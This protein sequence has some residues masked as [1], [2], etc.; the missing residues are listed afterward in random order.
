MPPFVTPSKLVLASA[1]FL[2]GIVGCGGPAGPELTPISGTV[3]FEGK[4]VGPGTVAFVPLDGNGNPA[5][6]TIDTSGRFKMSVYNPGDGVL[7]G[8]YKV[9]VTVVKEPAH[10]DDK[11]NLYPPTFLS[12]ERYMNPDSSGFNVTVEKRKPQDLKFDLKP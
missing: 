4:P 12:P 1:A 11:G 6:G 2:L 9:S 7:P 10:G 8:S 5:S 3:T